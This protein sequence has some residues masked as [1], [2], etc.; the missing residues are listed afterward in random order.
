METATCPVCGEV[1]DHADCDSALDF[2]DAC[3]VEHPSDEPC[4]EHCRVIIVCR[5]CKRREWVDGVRQDR[6][7]PGLFTDNPM[8]PNHKTHRELVVEA[9][10][11][12]MG[13]YDRRP[14]HV[15]TNC[16]TCHKLH[17]D[18]TCED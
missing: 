9:G 18:C 16:D 15:T 10:G 14:F 17:E 7:P 6:L 8:S 2:A 11:S 4:D 13:T 1:F 3:N 5:E 12:P